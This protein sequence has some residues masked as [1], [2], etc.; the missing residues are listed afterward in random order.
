[1]NVTTVLVVVQKVKNL[2]YAQRGVIQGAVTHHIIME[3]FVM[4]VVS[5]SL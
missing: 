4:E 5:P 1:M 2:I 3:K